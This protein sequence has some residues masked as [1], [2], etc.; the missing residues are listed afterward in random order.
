VGRLGLQKEEEAAAVLLGLTIVF[1]RSLRLYGEGEVEE[2]AEAEAEAEAEAKSKADADEA[3]AV[4]VLVV[5]VML[6]L[7][8]EYGVD[9]ALEVE[10]FDVKLTMWMDSGC[11]M[12]SKLRMGWLA[13]ILTL[14]SGTELQS[15]TLLLAKEGGG[16]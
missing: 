12:S 6:E 16:G 2:V 15:S 8:V 9:V 3:E 10:V 1:D 11:L 13:Y 4:V 7:V 14:C 5:V